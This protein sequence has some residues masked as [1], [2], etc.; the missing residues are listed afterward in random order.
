M[1]CCIKSKHEYKQLELLA[2]ARHLWFGSVWKK[3]GSTWTIQEHCS[4]LLGGGS[5]VHGLKQWSAGQ[6]V[7]APTPPFTVHVAF[8]PTEE[9]RCYLSGCRCPN[10]TLSSLGGAKF[11]GSKGLCTLNTCLNP[12]RAHTLSISQ[13]HSTLGSNPMGTLWTHPLNLAWSSPFI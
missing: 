13:T 7:S 1:R 6:Q 9:F 3:T 4:L 11:F 8:W 5:M 2:S 10:P 12:A